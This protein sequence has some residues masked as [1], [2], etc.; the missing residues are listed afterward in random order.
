[1]TDPL[2]AII[3]LLLLEQFYS[4]EHQAIRY[5]VRQVLRRIRHPWGGR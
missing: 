5:R 3:A 1:M 4:R 2:L